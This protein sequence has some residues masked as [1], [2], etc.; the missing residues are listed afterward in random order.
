[1]GSG[2][3]PRSPGRPS[4]QAGS[5]EAPSSASAGRAPNPAHGRHLKALLGAL[6]LLLLLAGPMA[7]SSAQESAT[8]EESQAFRI[9]VTAKGDTLREIAARTDVLR[10]P[11]RWIFLYRL[12]RDELAHLKLPQAKAPDTPLPAGLNIIYVSPEEARKQAIRKVSGR[13]WVVNLYSSTQPREVEALAVRLADEGYNT[14]ISR[15]YAKKNTW[16]RLRA[17]FFGN[18]EQA[19]DAGRQMTTFLGLPKFWVLQA[20]VKEVQEYS[21]YTD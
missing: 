4:V 14:Y 19:S 10:D 11:L 15:L 16:F 13:A 7:S 20:Q 3:S 5:R 1:M 9:H 8:D 18:H 17:G 12:N 2:S 21:G 6:A